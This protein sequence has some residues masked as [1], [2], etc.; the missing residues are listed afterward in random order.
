VHDN[1]V[2]IEAV[3]RNVLLGLVLAAGDLAYLAQARPQMQPWEQLCREEAATLK[4]AGMDLKCNQ[5]FNTASWNTQEDMDVA[6]WLRGVVDL[7]ALP[8]Y[9]VLAVL[10]GAEDH[11][12]TPVRHLRANSQHWIQAEKLTVQSLGASQ[13]LN[14]KDSQWEAGESDV[15]ELKTELNK[16]D[17]DTTLAADTTML[18]GTIGSSSFC[19]LMAL[20]SGEN[21]EAL[22]RRSEADPDDLGGTI[23]TSAL[24][25]KAVGSKDTVETLPPGDEDLAPSHTIAKDVVVESANGSEEI[26]GEDEDVMTLPAG[27]PPMSAASIGEATLPPGPNLKGSEEADVMTMPPGSQPFMT[28]MPGQ[29]VEPAGGA[30]GASNIISS[31]ATLKEGSSSNNWELPGTVL[32]S[33]REEWC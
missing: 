24:A 2:P 15:A 21:S 25:F 19:H 22:G 3:E 14:T 5:F 13:G 6:S 20:S 26:A 28:P 4:K 27:I 1:Q 16:M 10:D 9:Q 7:L 12:S 29:G 32:E 17:A 18:G 30:A 31:D 33:P 23:N 11:I 8:I